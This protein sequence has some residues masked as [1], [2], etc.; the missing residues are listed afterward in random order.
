MQIYNIYH[1]P[2]SSKLK[3]N[4][5][6]TYLFIFL[7][8]PLTLFPSSRDSS[9]Q[10]STISWLIEHD[11]CLTFFLFPTLLSLSLSLC[12]SYYHPTSIVQMTEYFRKF[13]FTLNQEFHPNTVTF[14]RSVSKARMYLSSTVWGP[15][16][17]F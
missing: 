10:S 11:F 12:L 6:L 5:E 15:R 13:N 8:F 3:K 17:N 7:Y 2:S 1:F 16:T 14:N 9:R 4:K